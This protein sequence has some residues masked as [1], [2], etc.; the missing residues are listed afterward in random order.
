MT[1]S[2][3]IVALDVSARDDVLKL[4]RMV[5]PHV[6]MVKLGLEG[7]VAHGPSLVT[8]LRDL[9]LQ[10]FLD[11]KLHDIPRTAAAA[12]KATQHLGVSLLTIHAAGGAEM[13][14]AVRDAVPDSTKV[15]AVTVLTSLDDA[16]VHALGYATNSAKTAR[17]LGKRALAHGADGLVCSAHEL[18]ALQDLGGMRV[19]PGIRPAG[20]AQG[21]QK[22]VATPKS[23][24]DAGAT[25]IVVGRPIVLAPDPAQAARAI[26]ESLAS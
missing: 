1:A 24:V 13:V 22:R 20:D 4:A 10:V 7:F 6:G 21:D 3:L 23:A 11:L 14:R 25:Y 2:R 8:A 5:A 9:G 26:V 17:T 19:V 18:G 16:E 15:L 12:A